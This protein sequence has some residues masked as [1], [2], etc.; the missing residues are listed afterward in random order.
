[1]ALYQHH[2]CIILCD[3]QNTEHIIMHEHVHVRIHVHLRTDKA[4]QMLKAHIRVALF[5][6]AV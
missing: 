2:V 5:K 4:Y 1:M 3:D 6:R